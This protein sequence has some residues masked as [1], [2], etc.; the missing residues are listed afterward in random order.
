MVFVDDQLF[1]VIKIKIRLV[2]KVLEDVFHRNVS[3][4]IAIQSQK[5]FT[6]GLKAIAEFG[7]EPILK[8][9]Q[10]LFDDFWLIFV[11]KE[12]SFVQISSLVVSVIRVLLD[13]IKMWEKVLFETV[14]INAFFLIAK[15]VLV[16]EK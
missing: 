3:V 7:L 4:I 1:E 16:S 8:V 9:D 10:S 14:E 5:G 11:I 15:N 2:T 13:Q 12:L 6:N